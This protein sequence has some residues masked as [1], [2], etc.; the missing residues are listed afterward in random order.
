MNLKVYGTENVLHDFS[1][2]GKLIF[3]RIFGDWRL[4]VGD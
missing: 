2:K 3:V 1:Y 4:E